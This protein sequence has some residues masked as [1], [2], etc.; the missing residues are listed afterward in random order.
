M[1][2]LDEGQRGFMV[3]QTGSGKTQDAIWH[4]RNT[5]HWPIVILDTKIED[6]F[7][8]VPEKKDKFQLIENLS[9]FEYLSKQKRDAYPDY[10]LVRPSA[11]EVQAVEPL[12][13]YL[14]LLYYNFGPVY[15]DIDEAY[16]FHNNGRCGPGYVALLTRG[17]SK[18]KTLMQ[19][20]QRP[21]WTSRFCLTE[22]QKVYVHHLQHKADIKYLSELVPGL[23]EVYRRPPK[24][25]FYFY[26]VG[27]E[28]PQLF[29]PVPYQ[30]L[31]DNA[32]ARALNS[33]KWL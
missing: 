8:G 29:S 9:D 23:D 25:H 11:Q 24:H 18:R 12:D 4:L 10:V 5:P 31:T 16:N 7:F 33:S 15:I 19:C 2:L 32:Q 28:T 6:D 21:V 13:E 22:S 14:Q 3:G 26:S 20:S 1:L 17:R 30:K 27:M